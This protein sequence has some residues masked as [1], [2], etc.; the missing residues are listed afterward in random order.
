MTSFKY[1]GA[2]VSDEGS[3]PKALSRISQATAALTKLK[4]I[5]RHSNMSLRSK[6]KLMRSLVI[7]IFLYAC[8]SWTLTEKLENRTQAFEIRCYRRLLNIL[9]KDH[10]INE[11]VGRKSQ[12]AIGKYAE[13]LTLVKK[14][15]IRVVWT[16]LKVFWLSKSNSAGHSA[17]KKKK[18]YRKI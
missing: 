18:R 7:F 5:W 13:L 14:T 6:V 10:V 3:K 15:E 16:C 8:E 11:N 12:S 2:L 4:Q 9:N 17:R 1:L